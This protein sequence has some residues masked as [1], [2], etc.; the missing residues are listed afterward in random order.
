ME[1]LNRLFHLGDIKKGRRNAYE[2]I[3]HVLE[4]LEETFYAYKGKEDYGYI[5]MACLNYFEDYP[6]RVFIEFYYEA[7]NDSTK[8]IRFSFYPYT[9]MFEISGRRT[10]FGE[11][12]PY[13]I[14]YNAN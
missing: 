6:E 4:Q 9:G 12:K 14:T 1:L 5:R 2:T 7:S 3:D 10:G 8:V 13:I 11:R